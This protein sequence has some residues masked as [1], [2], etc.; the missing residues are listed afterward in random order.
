MAITTPFSGGCACGAIRYECNEPPLLTWYCHCQSCQKASGTT[1]AANIW[2]NAAGLK[3][4]AGEPSTYVVKA[5][6]GNAT[7]RHFCQSCGSPLGMASDSFPDLACVTA[8]SLDNVDEF[9]PV[10]NIWTRSAFKCKS[11]FSDATSFQIQ[12]TEEELPPLIEATRT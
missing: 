3:F 1:N 7:Y 8:G 2:V 9:R 11:D 6:N 4:V 12:P 5:E 10:A